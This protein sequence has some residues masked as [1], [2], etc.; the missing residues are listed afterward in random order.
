MGGIFEAYDT[1]MGPNMGPDVGPQGS[2]TR[3]DPEDPEA[4]GQKKKNSS[5]TALR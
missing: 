1:P 3:R 2:R 5:T 4:Y